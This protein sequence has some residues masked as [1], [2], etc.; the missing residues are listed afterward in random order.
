[1]SAIAWCFNGSNGGIFFWAIA[2]PAMTKTGT[3][4][5]AVGFIFIAIIYLAQFKRKQ[6]LTKEL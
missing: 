4:R 3:K 2:E 5:M 6:V 1:M